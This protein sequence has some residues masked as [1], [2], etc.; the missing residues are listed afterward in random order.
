MKKIILKLAV[1]VVMSFKHDEIERS[2]RTTG[3]DF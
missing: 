3:Q 2:V 1:K